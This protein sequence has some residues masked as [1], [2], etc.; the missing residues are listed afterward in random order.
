MKP[1]CY[2]YNNVIYS[3]IKYCF[4]QIIQLKINPVIKKPLKQ[5]TAILDFYWR[6]TGNFTA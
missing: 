4:C 3:I 2:K 5:V 1:L 6:F